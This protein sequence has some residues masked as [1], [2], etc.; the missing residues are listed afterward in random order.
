MKTA[1]RPVTPRPLRVL[2]TTDAVGGVW[3]Y[4]MELV[5]GFSRLGFKVALAVMGGRPSRAA[6][7]DARRIV[8]L[9]LHESTFKLEWMPEPWADV[10]A[11]GHWLEQLC[12]SFRPDVVHLNEYSHGALA[13]GVP[14]LVVAHSSL[15]AWHEAV[16]GRPAGPEWDE[17]RRR[18]GAGLAG[19][20][21][22]ACPSVAA[23]GSLEKHHGPLSRTVVIPYGRSLDL[24]GPRAKEPIVFC[25]GRLWDEGKN[26]AVLDLAAAK[27]PWTVHAAGDTVA[28]DG[29]VVTA[30]SV[31]LLGRLHPRTISSWF[32]RAAIY[33]LPS[34]YEPFGLSALEAALSGCALVLGDLPS[35]R[36]VWEDA[37]LYVPADDAEALAHAIRRLIAS[38]H[39]RE[40]LSQRALGRAQMFGGCRMLDGYTKVYRELVS[41]AQPA[42]RF[43]AGR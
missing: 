10:D 3:S 16:L 37:A 42:A 4:S 2:M 40:Q 9:E 15:I 19:A 38:D 25:A 13:L 32:A 22:V 31:Q 8:G 14:T 29:R 27:L 33:A 17:Y 7:A 35:L 30:T 26:L 23:L 41:A 11:A 43:A 5:Q 36:E 18:V 28:P 6:R 12:A 34:R 24:E 1:P 39:L 21:V 20:S